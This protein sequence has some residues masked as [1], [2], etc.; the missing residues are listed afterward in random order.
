MKAEKDEDKNYHSIKENKHV[1]FSFANGLEINFH[2]ESSIITLWVSLYTGKEIV[3]IN[4]QTVSKKRSFRRKTEHHFEFNGNEYV[5]ELTLKSFLK[6]AWTCSLF[7]NG[8]L[9]KEYECK[10][11]QSEQPFHKKHPEFIYGGV[12]G[13]AFALGYISLYGILVIVI[14]GVIFSLWYMKRFL[15]VRENLRLSS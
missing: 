9:L 15:L 3:L 11:T 14:I 13:V 5:I 4:N 1:H 10:D 8:V 12:T 6:L 2:D 7:R